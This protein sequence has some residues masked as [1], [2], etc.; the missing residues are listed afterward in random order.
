LLHS[1]PGERTQQEIQRQILEILGDEERQR[2]VADGRVFNISE[3]REWWTK[4]RKEAEVNLRW[5]DLRHTFATRLM[6]SSKGRQGGL[7]SRFYCY[8]HPV[9][10][11]RS[12][13]VDGRDGWPEPQESRIAEE[14]DCLRSDIRLLTIRIDIAY[15]SHIR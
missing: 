3:N 8:D 15:I 14:R 5:H 13:D 12:T 10:S 1:R 11:R 7:R 4:A 9:C 6:A 2:M